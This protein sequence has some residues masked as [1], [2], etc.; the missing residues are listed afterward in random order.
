[1]PR[2][3]L[4]EYR[5]KQIVNSAIGEEYTGWSVT[6]S[7]EVKEITG[8]SKYVVKVDQAV[9]GRFKKGLVRLGV[10]EKQLE[11]TVKDLQNEG[12]SSFI[13]EPFAAYTPEKERYFSI[14]RDRA[15]YH[16]SYSSK[17]GVDIEEHPESIK[18][19][20]VSAS[21][22]WQKLARA[23]GI[24]KTHLLALL[25]AFKEHFFVFLEINPYI[26]DGKKLIILD[27]A[28]EVDDAAGYFVGAWRETDFRSPKMMM[29]NDSEKIVTNLDANS[30]AS[31]NLNVLNEDGS[32]FLLLSGG[33]AS[34]VVADEV[35]NRGYGR[36][37][38]NYGEYSGN[39]NTH[40]TYV[41]TTEVLK[42]LLKSQA[43]KKV[44]FVGGAV[45]N[46]T[47]IA[48]TFA[49][50]I[51]AIEERAK[52]LAEQEV[53]FFVRRGGPRQEVGL[54]KIRGALERHGLLGG[55]Y[56]PTTSITDALGMALEG[57]KE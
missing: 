28:V 10:T 29:E 48:N 14:S 35:Y 5:A 40:E 1:M 51:H 36:Q 43:P 9:K 15:G 44:M 3:K 7:T 13:V 55:V 24:P 33:G 41:Y 54:A 30:P 50:V 18:T 6:D 22:D 57:V 52:E 45:A 21:T 4:S 47:D 37:L 49:G 25:A 56:D 23:T 53:K 31:F 27:A 11:S 20:T 39:P 8:H 32:V 46:F 19:V 34:V 12:Y 42:L 38:A 16:I 26:R 2:R 17:G